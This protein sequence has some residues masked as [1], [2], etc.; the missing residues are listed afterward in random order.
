MAQIRK[1]KIGA[2]DTCPCW[3][4]AK[5]KKCCRG[6]VDWPTILAGKDGHIDHLSARGRNLVFADVIY[7]AL[8]LDTENPPNLEAWKRAFTA[9]AIRKIYEVTLPHLCSHS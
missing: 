5:Y 4:G 1:R 7:D 3:S 2:N 6:K 8:Q 9:D